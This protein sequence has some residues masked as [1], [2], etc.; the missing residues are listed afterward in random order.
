MPFYSSFICGIIIPFL[1]LIV[2]LVSSLE[3]IKLI[4]NKRTTQSVFEKSNVFYR[5][6]RTIL[7]RN[8]VPST[9]LVCSSYIC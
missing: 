4:S 5:P 1:F 8:V 6:Q 7:I 2:F 9:L 3:E